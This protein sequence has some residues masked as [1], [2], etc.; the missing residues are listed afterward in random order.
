MLKQKNQQQNSAHLPAETAEV[1]T[2]ASAETLNCEIVWENWE[3]T[4]LSDKREKQ[5]PSIL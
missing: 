2:E 1:R 3:E 5:N 4:V